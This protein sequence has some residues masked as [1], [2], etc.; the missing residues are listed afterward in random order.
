MSRQFIDTPN[1]YV[2]LD[3]ISYVHRKKDGRFEI[4]TVGGILDGNRRHF[5][6]TIVQYLPAPAD[7]ECLFF[8]SDAPDSY[9][10]E[11]IIAFGQTITGELVPVTLGWMEGIFHDHGRRKV[12][13]PQIF[14]DD[15][16]YPNIDDWLRSH[17]EQESKPGV[18]IGP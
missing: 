5:D 6:R 18:A 10:A 2:S 17:S 13:I 1:G 14:E 7:L 15:I 3:E 11:P 8:D 9:F 12:G 4:G 16:T